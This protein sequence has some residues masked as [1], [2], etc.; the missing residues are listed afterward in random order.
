MEYR[1]QNTAQSMAGVQ[2]RTVKGE[3]HRTHTRG[4]V[5]FKEHHPEDLSVLLSLRRALG[6]HLHSYP[7]GRI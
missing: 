5:P 1:L 6:I 3:G 4:M 2:G 7:K